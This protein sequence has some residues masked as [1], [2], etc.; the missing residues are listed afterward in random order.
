MRESPIRSSTSDLLAVLILSLAHRSAEE[1]PRGR[2]TSA[3]TPL[4]LIVITALLGSACAV[5]TANRN[6]RAAEDR[7][8]FDTAVVEYTKALR[9]DPSNTDARTSLERAKIRSATDH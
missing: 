9:L 8:D 5:A 3:R 1:A 6:G 4:L 7:M 2:P